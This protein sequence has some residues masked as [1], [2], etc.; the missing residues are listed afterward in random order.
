MA[1]PPS[2]SCATTHPQPWRRARPKWESRRGQ[3]ASTG[4]RASARMRKGQEE[5]TGLTRPVACTSRRGTHGVLTGY[6]RGT[7]GVLTGYPR[8]TH[9]VLTGYPPAACRSA[10]LGRGRR[11]RARASR[12]TPR[13][14][15]RYSRGTRYG[16]HGVLMGVLTGYSRGTHACIAGHATHLCKA[17]HSWGGYSR[18]GG[19][20]GGTHKSTH[21]C[22]GKGT[23]TAAI[24]PAVT[25][26]GTQ[27][28]L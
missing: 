25:R 11:R 13:T 5:G 19:A 24:G 2:M 8:G 16:T 27:G 12:G 23:P 6:S 20:H 21:A 9:G 14:C 10:R 7:H 3:P 4:E 17:R 26:E 28:V 22:I 15:A 18:V 1:S